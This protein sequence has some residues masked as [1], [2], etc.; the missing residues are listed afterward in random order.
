M[1]ELQY[2]W[3]GRCEVCGTVGEGWEGFGTVGEGCGRASVQ[4]ER[5]LGGLRYSSRGMGGLLYGKREMGGLRFG[6]RETGAL[7]FGSR[8]R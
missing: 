3:R 1:G 7:R 2:S 6:K 4:L 5:E 8:G